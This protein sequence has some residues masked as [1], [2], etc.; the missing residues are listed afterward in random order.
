MAGN[1]RIYQQS[2]GATLTGSDATEALVKFCGNPWRF[3]Q[4]FET[5]L[6]NLQPFVKAIVS[7]TELVQ[8]AS[9]TI[10][11][12][13]FEPEGLIKLLKSYS[14]P[15]NLERGFSLTATGQREVEELLRVV[16]SEWIDFLF[17]PE[18]QSFA[19]Y[20]DHDEFT[21]L[22]AHTRAN[23]DRIAGALLNQGFKVAENYERRF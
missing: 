18:S 10:D 21:T 19:V 11:E 17:I 8:A 16:L 1:K 2:R 15:P 22:Y 23:L 20:A 4:T 3:Q 7:A 14:I 6:G 5:P 12:V 9:L 13:V